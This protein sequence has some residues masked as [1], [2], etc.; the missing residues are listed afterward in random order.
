[1]GFPLAVGQTCDALAPHQQDMCGCL[2]MMMQYCGMKLEMCPAGTVPSPGTIKLP[3]G[4]KESCEPVQQSRWHAAAV[5]AATVQVASAC[6]R[7]WREES[8]AG[9]SETAIFAKQVMRVKLQT[10]CVIEQPSSTSNWHQ[11]LQFYVLIL[12]A[13]LQGYY[14]TYC[15]C[16][17]K[18]RLFQVWN[19]W[20]WLGTQSGLY[21]V[22]T[23]SNVGRS[24]LYTHATMVVML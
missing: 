13:K 2:I 3:S 12:G 9:W 8:S 1:M 6:C 24:M 4:I 15:Q 21:S 7:A 11:L 23:S 22:A 10:D 18:G 20:I 17:H 16:P 19:Y 14:A 5:S